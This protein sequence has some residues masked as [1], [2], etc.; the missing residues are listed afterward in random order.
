MFVNAD[1]FLHF[2]VGINVSSRASDRTAVSLVRKETSCCGNIQHHLF[3]GHFSRASLWGQMPRRH[4][5]FKYI[6]V[7]CFTIKY[8]Y[9]EQAN[10]QRERGRE[11]ERVC[12]I[13]LQEW[14]DVPF[15]RTCDTNITHMRYVFVTVRS[16]PEDS[17]RWQLLSWS[18]TGHQVGQGMLW[19]TGQKICECFLQYQ[20]QF[21]M[22]CVTVRPF[23]GQV[24]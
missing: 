12:T 2:S 11:R 4:T 19:C 8:N 7:A 16:E 14:W 17:E 6:S 9:G 21:V 23:S 24:R 1:F 5:I 20:F 22:M 15:Q 18:Y 10:K 3:E 13:L